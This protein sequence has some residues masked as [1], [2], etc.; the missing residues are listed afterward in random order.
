M[1]QIE[2]YETS[3]IP[4]SKMQADRESAVLSTFSRDSWTQGSFSLDEDTAKR[5]G[6]SR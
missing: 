1:K 4:T 3:A 2:K 6:Q 5:G